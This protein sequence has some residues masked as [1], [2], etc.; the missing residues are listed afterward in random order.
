MVGVT[1]R[2]YRAVRGTLMGVILYDGRGEARHWEAGGVG[3][4][5]TPGPSQKSFVE[6]KAE[7]LRKRLSLGLSTVPE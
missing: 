1:L 2:R 5:D 7:L 3:V 6:A 4:G